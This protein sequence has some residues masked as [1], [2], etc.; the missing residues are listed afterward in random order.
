MLYVIMHT[1]LH[2]IAHTP[3]YTTLHHAHHTHTHT[4][5][6]THA[7]T[8]TRTPHPRTPSVCGVVFG[9]RCV[10]VVLRGMYGVRAYIHASKH[11]YKTYNAGRTTVTP[12]KT[13]VASCSV[14]IA[15]GEG[16][17]LSR[18]VCMQ[19]TKDPQGPPR[20]PPETPR[21]P[22]RTPQGSPRDLPG[23]PRDPQGPLGTPPGTPRCRP[24]YVY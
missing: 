17:I 8:H 22:P 7:R 16:Y 11:I 24:K 12:S 10:C 5:A 13:R 18:Y 21:N 6:R 23:T 14:L 9:V 1:A 2:R 3:H 15:T 20:D 19:K 4:H